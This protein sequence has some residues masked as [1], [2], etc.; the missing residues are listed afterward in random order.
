MYACTCSCKYRPTRISTRGSRYSHDR[1][2]TLFFQ[3]YDPRKFVAPAAPTNKRHKRSQ[4]IGPAWAYLG[5][6]FRIKPPNES[7][8]GIK[9]KNCIHKLYAQNQ[10][11]TPEFHSPTIFFLVKSLRSRCVPTVQ[12]ASECTL[13]LRQCN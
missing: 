3:L 1:P 9:A 11:K 13:R 12:C 5:E 6:R 8:P 10:W 4:Y 7:V 2:Y